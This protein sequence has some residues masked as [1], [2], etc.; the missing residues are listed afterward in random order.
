[1]LNLARGFEVLNIAILAH[2]CIGS[3]PFHNHILVFLMARWDCFE[4]FDSGDPLP[5]FLFLIVGGVFSRIVLRGVDGI[6]L[7][8]FLVRRDGL[9]LSQLLFVD[10]M[11]LFC[12]RK[13]VSYVY[14]AGGGPQR[15]WNVGFRKGVVFWVCRVRLREVKSHVSS[16]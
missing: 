6:I 2:T 3:I 4:K 14:Q 11:I 10:G 7:K 15:M 1:M 5:S 16:H 9:T 12:S 13:E 8:G